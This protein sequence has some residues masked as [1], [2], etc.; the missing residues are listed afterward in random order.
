MY[1]GQICNLEIKQRVYIGSFSTNPTK[2]VLDML[3]PV[4]ERRWNWKKTFKHC[5]FIVGE[6]FELVLKM[7]PVCFGTEHRWLVRHGGGFTPPT[8]SY[9]VHPNIFGY[10]QKKGVPQKMDNFFN[11][12]PP[13]FYRWFGGPTPMFG[14]THFSTSK[15][16]FHTKTSCGA[17]IRWLKKVMNWIQEGFPCMWDKYTTRKRNGEP[18]RFTVS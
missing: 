4:G 17:W 6:P 12:K 8:R 15:L 16:Y 9:L 13:S 7:I 10:F 18:R 14:N 11:G 2:R 5:T 1:R 3:K